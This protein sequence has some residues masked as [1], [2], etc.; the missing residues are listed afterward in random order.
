MCDRTA[1]DILGL[2]AQIVSA[3]VSHDQVA[4]GELPLLIDGLNRSL[5]I[6]GQAEPKPARSPIPAVPL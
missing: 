4:P 5:T 2:A 3:H 1:L 6:P